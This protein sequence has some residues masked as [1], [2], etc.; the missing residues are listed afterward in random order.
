MNKIFF[1]DLNKHINI[2]TEIFNQFIKEDKKIKLLESIET[3]IT[4]KKNT[5]KIEE[6]SKYTITEKKDIIHMMYNNLKTVKKFILL[7]IKDFDF[8]NIDIIVKNTLKIE[9]FMIINYINTIEKKLNNKEYE[10]INTILKEIQEFIKK[11]NKIKTEAELEEI[12]DPD[13]II[14][15]IKNDLLN[16]ETIINFGLKLSDEIT[17]NGSVSLSEQK[18]NYIQK[19]YEQNLTTNKLMANII[20][21]NLESIYMVYDEILS[22]HELVNELQII[23]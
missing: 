13:Y 20:Y 23:T 9:D 6:S 16:K 5:I 4:I 1:I 2:Y 7:Y 21:T 11:M 22:F 19:M 3:Y 15:L 12:I 18:K 8:K 10:Y 14:Q 17:K